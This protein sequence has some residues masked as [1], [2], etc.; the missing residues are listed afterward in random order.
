MSIRSRL[1][2][3]F[4]LLVGGTC[5]AQSARSTGSDSVKVYSRSPVRWDV[6]FRSVDVDVATLIFSYSAS[7]SIDVDFVNLTKES[8]GK[9]GLRLGAEWVGTGGAGGDRNFY[10]DLNALLRISAAGDRGRFDILLGTCVRG[11]D[12]WGFGPSNELASKIG[13]E[14]RLNIVSNYLGLLGKV[15]ISERLTF[16]GVGLFLGYDSWQR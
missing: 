5:F 10:H 16:V 9:V 11:R 14:V 4:V 6:S 2:C 7:G 12:T 13:V 8:T 1:V 3:S 15:S